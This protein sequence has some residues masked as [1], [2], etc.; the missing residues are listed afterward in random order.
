MYLLDLVDYEYIDSEEVTGSSLGD[1]KIG[2]FLIQDCNE[3]QNGGR[4]P[5]DQRCKRHWKC[6]LQLFYVV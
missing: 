2:I 3:N 6:H 1:V 4:D 5:T